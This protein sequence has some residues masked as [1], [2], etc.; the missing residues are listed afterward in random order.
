LRFERHDAEQDGEERESAEAEDGALREGK[1]LRHE[2]QAD[3]D[4]QDD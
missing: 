4:A 2:A 1:D 3:E